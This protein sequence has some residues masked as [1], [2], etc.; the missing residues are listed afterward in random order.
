MLKIKTIFAVVILAVSSSAALAADKVAVFNLERAILSTEAAKKASS[1]LQADPEFAALRA[2]YEGLVADMEKLRDEQNSKGMT[3]NTEQQAEHRK[4][5]DYIRADL[6]LAQKK[7]QA[8][9]NAAVRGLM[10]DLQAKTEKALEEVIKSEGITVV[11]NAAQVYHADKKAD[12][13]DK[14]TARLNKM[15]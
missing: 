6:E 10:Q 2:K 4:K 1:D 12:I 9:Q 8:E 3:W 13:T 14:V 5:V 11:L 7:L 15:K